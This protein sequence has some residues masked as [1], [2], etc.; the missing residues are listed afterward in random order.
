MTQAAQKAQ[1]KVNSSKHVHFKFLA[2]V[3]WLAYVKISHGAAVGQQ[4][5]SGL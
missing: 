3:Q 2:P 4:L 1:S 5:T